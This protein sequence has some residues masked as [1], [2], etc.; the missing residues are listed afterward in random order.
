MNSEKVENTIRE[1]QIPIM[2]KALSA[3]TALLRIIQDENGIGFHVDLYWKKDAMFRLLAVT[4]G[5]KTFRHLGRFL[6]WAANHDITRV[7]VDPIKLTPEMVALLKNGADS[8]DAKGA[9]GSKSAD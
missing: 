1:Q 9:A 7:E 5:H 2:S 6:K 4:G 3:P 8:E